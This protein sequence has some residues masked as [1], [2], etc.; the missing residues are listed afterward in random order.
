MKVLVDS[1]SVFAVE[2]CMISD[3]ANCLSPERVMMLDDI[4]FGNIAA[5]TEDSLVERRRTTE[6]L[7]TLNEDILTMI[8]FSRH[9][10]T[11][12]SRHLLD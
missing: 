12:R 7:Q 8:R 3:L 1:F 2:N 9:K 6:K 4:L 10:P 11:D 5:E